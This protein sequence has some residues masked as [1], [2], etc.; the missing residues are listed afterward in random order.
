[1]PASA[2]PQPGPSRSAAAP[3]A[4]P[5]G[6]WRPSAS[7]ATLRTRARMLARTRTF[8]A[9]RD[10]LEVEVPIVQRGANCDRGVDPVALA[11]GYL[12][13]SPEHP[14]K[15]LLAA[16]YGDVW[17]CCP[18][19]R[20]GELG[21]YH[22]PAFRMLEWYRVGM[23]LDDLIAE[24]LA[25]LAAITDLGAERVVRHGYRDL[26]RDR[27]AVDPVRAS[28]NDLAALLEP[29]ERRATGDDRNAILD[30]LLSTRLQPTF[31]PTAWTV[32][33]GWPPDQAA[34]AAIRQHADGSASAARFEI[35]RGALELANGYH[36]LTD[37]AELDRRL[38]AEADAPARPARLVTDHRLRA[39]LQAGLPPC[40]GVAVG[41]DRAVLLAC[42]CPDL[43]TTMAF[44][45]QRR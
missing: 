16:G 37:A 25:L 45:W 27:L 14:L 28:S 22:A 17:T 20:S 30:L 32:V 12:I 31:D 35:Y 42:G 2:S 44:A 6:D 1:M 23:C 13:T 11:D 43:A 5:H 38:A 40:S 34:Q 33:D 10:V 7:L 9:E 26:F 36:E 21:R 8:F 15:R 39:A 4:P 19:F 3:S 29:D 41:F 18:C 24:T